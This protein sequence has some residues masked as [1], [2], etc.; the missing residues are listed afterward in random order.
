MPVVAPQI[1]Y[2]LQRALKEAT[3]RPRGSPP[4]SSNDADRS[5]LDLFIKTAEAELTNGRTGD[6]RAARDERLARARREMELKK[7][8]AEAERRLGL[9]KQG[10][11]TDI[12][13]DAL[14]ERL[15]ATGLDEG[16]LH[17]LRA[18]QLWL[19]AAE[20]VGALRG[21]AQEMEMV[22]FGRK[23]MMA[24]RAGAPAGPS[25]PQPAAPFT[26]TGAQ[27]AGASQQLQGNFQI[28]KGGMITPLAGGSKTAPTH[29]L[30]H[31]MSRAEREAAVLRQFH[32]APT[33][34]IEQ[35]AEREV[36]D[37]MA[38]QQADA[39]AEAAKAA[40]DPDDEAI[41]DRETLK[42][43]EW[44]DWKDDNPRG[45]GNKQGR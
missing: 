1:P 5:N 36:A 35:L 25:R 8:V 14:A 26:V 4:R 22:E 6:P 11:E 12:S 45:D 43:R 18:T 3:S 7:A 16:K 13:P 41:V 24:G 37:A 27:G 42:A 38:R 33:E 2:L 21:A 20:S 23:R 15:V 39:E 19:A 31:A 40:E 17:E 32:T 30:Q 28:A 34:T 44:D 10:D 9:S 29:G